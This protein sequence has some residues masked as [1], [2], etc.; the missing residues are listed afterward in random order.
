MARTQA[1]SFTG[2]DGSVLSGRLDL[3]DGTV[4]A[5][6]LFAHCFT[7]SKDLLA[8]RRISAALTRAGLAVLRFDFTGLGQ[9]E[10]DFQATN[11]SSNVQDLVRA[12]DH[13]RATRAAPAL[14]VGH[15]LGG[16]AV[17]AAAADIPEAVAVATIGAPADAEHVLRSFA[18]AFDTIRAEGRAEVTLAGRRFTLERQF[19]DDVAGQRLHDRIAGLRRAL[20]V[21]HAPRDEVV[22]IDNASR[23]FA[24]AHHPKSFVSL[25]EADHLLS[26]PADGAYAGEV[27]AAWAGR[28]L[29]A[30]PARDAAGERAGVTVAETG[31][32]RYQASVQAGRHRLLADEPE[33]VGGLDSGPSPYDY[34]SAAL[35]ACTVMTLRMYA[36]R[37]GLPVERI[38]ATVTHGKIHAEDCADCAEELRAKG[39]TIDRFERAIAIDGELDPAARAR[40]LE[41]ADRCPVHRTLEAGAAIVTRASEP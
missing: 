23:I 5:H 27:I 39:G 16:T 3:P 34:L 19:L 33:R 9:S 4:R 30:E 14:L 36:Q 24:A 25:D 41:I 31:L 2:H 12:A 29:P 38:A 17:L 40:L 6:A 1:I 13:L 21:L 32:G 35:G 18:E 28:Y 11:F 7:C 8:A 22:G 37:K 15:S 26:Q 10:G 20:L